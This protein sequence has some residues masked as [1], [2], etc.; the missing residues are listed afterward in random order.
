MAK[1][2]RLQI[3][4]IAIAAIT[5]IAIAGLV[6][7][8]VTQQTNPQKSNEPKPIDTTQQ[9]LDDWYQKHPETRPENRQ[10]GMIYL[11]PPCEGVPQ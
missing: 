9:C 3:Y 2:T 5:A 1:R 6:F 8:Q 10:P 11:E 4:I 7:W